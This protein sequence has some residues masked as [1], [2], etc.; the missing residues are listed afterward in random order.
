[1]LLTSGGCPRAH[2]SLA[3]VVVTVVAGLGVV[4]AHQLHHVLLQL[5]LCVRILLTQLLE[6]QLLG[7]WSGHGESQELLENQRLILRSA[8]PPLVQVTP[9]GVLK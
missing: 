6:D 2:C 9:L 8:H 3:A 7:E 1:M 5:G 4:V